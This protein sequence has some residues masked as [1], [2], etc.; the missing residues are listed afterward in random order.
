MID[1]LVAHHDAR[2]LAAVLKCANFR[3][4]RLL[5]RLG[6]A[7]A[8]PEAHALANVDPDECLMQRDV[9]AA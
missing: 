1:E 7:R 9:A 2:G 3:S 4:L 6:F 5:E 8:S